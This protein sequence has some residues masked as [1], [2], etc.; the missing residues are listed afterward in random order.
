MQSST[1]TLR[2]LLV[3]S[4]LPALVGAVQAADAPPANPLLVESTLPLHFPRFDQ[5]HDADFLPAFEQGIAEHRK[6]IEA[7]ASNPAKPTFDNTI[8]AMERAGRTLGRVES[9]FS[10]L[11]SSNTDPALQNVQRQMAPK[12]AA[13]RDEVQLDPRLFARI[14]ALYQQRDSLGLDAESARLLWRYHQDFV[15]AGAQLSEA[16]KAK[17]RALNT[18]LATLQTT[19]EQNTLKERGASAVTFDTRAELAGLSEVEIRTRP[20]RRPR[21]ASRASSSSSWSTPPASR[22]SPTS[23]AMRRA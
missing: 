1:K 12:F 16:S 14:D 10:N 4:S 13:H 3:A 23:R 20:T 8:V 6:E 2:H 7:I 17:L 22:Y 5:I 9:I 11:T 21:P 18:E 15:R 19:F